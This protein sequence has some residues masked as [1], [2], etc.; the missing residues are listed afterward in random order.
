M[1]DIKIK[2]GND[3]LVTN[4]T[5]SI[6]TVFFIDYQ[7]KC[8]PCDQW[9]DFSYTILNWWTYLMLENAHKDSALLEL[10]FMDGP[11]KMIVQ[12]TASN[13]EFDCIHFNHNLIELSFVCT[14]VDFLYALYD[15]LKSLSKVLYNNGMNV[16]EIKPAY[17]QT[18]LMIKELRMAIEKLKSI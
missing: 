2:V 8:F 17:E 3:V 4:G 6:D 12:K 16:G 13:L 5:G 18:N 9:T 15:A 1:K 10:F 7:G 14:I 11:Y